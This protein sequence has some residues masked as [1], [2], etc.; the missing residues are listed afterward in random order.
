MKNKIKNSRITYKGF[1]QRRMLNLIASIWFDIDNDFKDNKND[2][3]YQIQGETQSET[4]NY[5]FGKCNCKS[6]VF[7]LKIL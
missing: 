7:I 2:Q 5:K 1:S 3:I 6:F 4:S